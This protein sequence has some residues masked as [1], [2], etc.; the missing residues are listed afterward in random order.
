MSDDEETNSSS[1]EGSSEEEM[2]EEYYDESTEEEESENEEMEDSEENNNNEE[3]DEENNSDEEDEDEKVTVEDIKKQMANG[4]PELSF[5]REFS[6]E[7]FV[8]LLELLKPN[9]ETTITSLDV[10]GKGHE[11]YNVYILNIFHRV[12]SWRRKN[13]TYFRGTEDKHITHRICYLG[14]G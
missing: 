11:C 4:K 7:G 13:R 14:Y 3:S 10:G 12:Q 9:S 1:F 6:E 8:Y 2:S 5:E